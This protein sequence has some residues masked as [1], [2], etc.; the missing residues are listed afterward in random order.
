[1]SLATSLLTP[2]EVQMLADC[3]EPIIVLEVPATAETLIQRGLLVSAEVSR[4]QLSCH[5]LAVTERGR[6][7]VTAWVGRQ[8]RSHRQTGTER[9]LIEFTA[10]RPSSRV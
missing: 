7:Y 3:I 2:E 5:G 8:E 6:S 1:M 10:V 9:R 4:D